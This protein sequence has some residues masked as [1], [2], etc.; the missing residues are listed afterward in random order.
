MSKNISRRRFL[1]GAAATIAT[2]YIITSK[3]LG[4]PGV[5][6]ASN[7]ITI[8]TI[9]HGNQMPG[10]FFTARDNPQ[11]QVVAVSDVRRERREEWKAKAE[12]KH[13]GVTAYADF[14]E[15]LARPDID[16]VIIAT[17]D[18]WHAPM[19]ILAAKAGKDIYCEKPLTLTIREAR[20]FADAVRR[21]DR[22]LQTGSMQR[23]MGQ[24]RQAAE[25]VRNGRIGTVKTIHIGLPNAGRQSSEQWVPE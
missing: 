10:L 8:G 2:P 6:S 1:G 14:R 15:L 7:R 4:A 25:L 20:A 18:H 16:A 9:G 23:S 22:V 11:S 19:G 13:K 5:E 21:Y 24:F 17:P 3:A 12:E